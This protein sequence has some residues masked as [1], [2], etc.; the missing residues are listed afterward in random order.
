MPTLN[1]ADLSLAIVWL[2]FGIRGYLR[3]LVKEAGSLA[4]IVLGFYC[5]GAYHKTLTPHL[6]EYISG[7]YA[8]TAAY[9]LIFTVTLLGVWFL[10]LAVSGMVKIT[11]TQWADRFF[12]GAFGVAKGVVLTAALLF[13]IHLASPHPDFLKGSTLVPVLDRVSA[14][15]SR[16]IPPD[17]N[18]KL[19][20]FSHKDAPD[21]VKAA[22]EKKAAP[23]KKPAEPVKKPETD[24]KSEHGK[25]PPEKGKADAKKPQA[26]NKPAAK[27]T[28]A[29]PAKEQ[30]HAATGGKPKDASP[31]KTAAKAENTE[32]KP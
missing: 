22:A 10:A 18:E 1:I 12:G 11:M 3:G 23:E 13:L 25:T 6:T 4:A 21:P 16:Y 7:N 15:L 32:K 14:K 31:D 19:R 8:G 9:L 27:S 24:K 5:A 20:K 29:D 2:Y 30:H 28:K 17:I 26:D